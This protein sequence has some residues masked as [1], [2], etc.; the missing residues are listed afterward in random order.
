MN[1][2][3]SVLLQ[4]DEA[5]HSQ[6]R[7]DL[8]ADEAEDE[9]AALA[10]ALQTEEVQL[11]SETTA[12]TPAARFSRPPTFASTSSSRASQPTRRPALG[13]PD[14]ADD[15]ELALELQAQEVELL[16]SPADVV[17]VARRPPPSRT[18]PGNSSSSSSAAARHEAVVH[19][20][21]ELARELQAQEFDDVQLLSAQGLPPAAAAAAASAAAAGALPPAFGM[22]PHARA[23]FAPRAGSAGAASTRR[24][25]SSTTADTDCIMVV[26][27]T[28][29][30]EARAR[31]AAQERRDA[32]MAARLALEEETLMRQELMSPMMLE[33]GPM[34]AVS[35]RDSRYYGRPAA[36]PSASG[37]RGSRG[38][39][40]VGGR[41]GRSGG[42]VRGYPR[43]YAPG[44]L[45][46]GL[47]HPN[48]HMMMAGGGSG[49]G[50]DIGDSYEALLALDE[51]IRKPGAS[52]A[53][54]GSA[55]VLHTVGEADVSR[56]DTC[57]ICLDEYAPGQVTRRLACLCIFHKE[58]I[59]RYFE[60][61]LLCPICRRDI[62]ESSQAKV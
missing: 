34:G 58:C 36:V 21:E 28:D 39:R 13:L 62:R 3:D 2:D 32:E 7:V 4:E 61:N 45:P 22:R 52:A 30:A 49:S 6:H 44:H 17:A 60:D 9:D 26:D 27:G 1:L 42:R 29:T 48:L 8:T 25:S 43:L 33:V 41:N 10:L 19:D 31:R 35:D 54:L 53:L 16:S 37:W 57:T 23:T 47:R 46:Y 38:L 12:A 50:D 18:R 20:D 5:R 40:G 59:D 14:T 55:S 51:T 24:S 15:E 56:L 11:L